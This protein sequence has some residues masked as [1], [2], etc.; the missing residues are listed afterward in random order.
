MTL[1]FTASWFMRSLLPR[2]MLLAL[3]MVLVIAFFCLY[4]VP[5]I[6]PGVGLLLFK[7]GLKQIVSP[8]TGIIV[9]YTKEEGDDI[10]KGEIVALIRS[11]G[12]DKERPILAHISGHIAEIIAYPDTE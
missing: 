1:S 5:S 12:Q 7:G 11:H 4:K 8:Y 6:V 2:I 9:S 10:A 3:A